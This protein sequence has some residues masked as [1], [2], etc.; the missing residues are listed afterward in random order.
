M[1]AVPAPSSRL[2]DAESDEAILARFVEGDP[3]ALGMLAERYER[4]L[5]GLARGLLGGSDERAR[6]AVQDTWLR[7]I[8][9]GA[10]FRGDSAVGTWLYRITVNRCH[11]LRTAKRPATRPASDADAA[12]APTRE[13]DLSMNL[14]RAV[15]A[16]PDD[17]RDAVLLCSHAGLTH[18]QA[19]AVLE[20]PLGTLKTRQRAALVALRAR[21]AEET[22]P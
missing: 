16:L 8:R 18:E 22:R 14:R 19:A 21:L 5:L 13:P 6:D 11:T 3:D 15:D 2:A 1:T 12:V 4:R 7:V 9:A 20:I 10:A 17:H